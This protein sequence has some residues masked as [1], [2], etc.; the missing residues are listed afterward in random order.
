[1]DAGK[2][3]NASPHKDVGWKLQGHLKAIRENQFEVAEII[4]LLSQEIPDAEGA[5]EVLYGLDQQSQ[6]GL[7][8]C[9]TK[10]GGMWERWQR[11]A[12]KYGEL[13]DAYRIW[14]QRKGIP[15]HE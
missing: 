3:V 9:S 6:I 1:M 5:R 4:L 12:L 11:D 7:W 13:T 10:Q 2:Y 15:Y 8:S 14:C